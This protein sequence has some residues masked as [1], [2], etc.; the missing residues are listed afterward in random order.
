MSRRQRLDIGGDQI[1]QEGAG[2]LAGNP[3]DAAI[4]EQGCFDGSGLAR[5]RSGT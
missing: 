2:G 1:I 3:Q 4:G 5:I